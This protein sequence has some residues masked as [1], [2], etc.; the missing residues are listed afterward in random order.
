MKNR[1]LFGMTALIM[2][3][4]CLSICAPAVQAT[5]ADDTLAVTIPVSVTDIGYKAEEEHVIMLQALTAGADQQLAIV[6]SGE[7][8]FTLTFDKLGVYKYAVSQVSGMSE[9]GNYDT[10]VYEITVYVT[11]DL[12]SGEVVLNMSISNGDTK[13]E[14]CDFENMYTKNLTVKK[15]WSNDQKAKRPESVT[16]N[17]IK[18]EENAASIVLNAENEWTY[19][20]TALDGAYDWSVAEVVPNGY[21]ATY[22]VDGET[23]TITNTYA[24]IQTGQMNWPI[25]VF[26]V[27]GVLFLGF[28]AALLGRKKEI[29]A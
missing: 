19:T 24:L 5:E 26:S 13:V 20:W 9:R 8:Q 18:G 7:D 17:L 21:K 29:D 10:T 1:V 15:V 6:G 4:C 14:S 27:I 22:T 2:L 12:E 3:V 28:G 23:V 16:I 11:K 25:V